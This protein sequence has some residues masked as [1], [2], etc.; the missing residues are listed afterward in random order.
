[1]IIASAKILDVNSPCDCNEPT[2]SVI[3]AIVSASLQLLAEVRQKKILVTT[4]RKF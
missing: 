2:I 1:M 3:K 4:D